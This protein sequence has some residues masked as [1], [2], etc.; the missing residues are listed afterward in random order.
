MNTAY[1]KNYST[2]LLESTQDFI[3]EKAAPSYHAA[4][5]EAM[6]DESAVVRKSCTGQ[7]SLSKE[8]LDIP[9]KA[10]FSSARKDEPLVGQRL[11]ELVC[12]TPE[13]K[14]LL[15]LL[16]TELAK[17]ENKEIEKAVSIVK[18]WA[19]E[20]EYLLK[21]MNTNNPETKRM[22]ERMYVRWK[23]AS[24]SRIQALSES[25]QG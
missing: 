8:L 16:E 2:Q 24:E 9:Q 23:N 19:K 18:Q 11:M 20:E 25:L 21:R 13:P 22:A 3:V 4:V 6:N 17:G 12:N 14:N 10:P 5:S 1:Q 7:A 15:A